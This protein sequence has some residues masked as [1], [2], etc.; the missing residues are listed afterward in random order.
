VG[1]LTVHLYVSEWIQKIADITDVA[2]SIHALVSDKKF[3]Q[4]QAMLPA[5]KIYPHPPEPRPRAALRVRPH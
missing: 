3:D 2:H 1:K 5:E 4:A